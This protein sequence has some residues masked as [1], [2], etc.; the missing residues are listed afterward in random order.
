MNEFPVKDLGPACR[1]AAPLHLLTS[2]GHGAATGCLNSWTAE[3]NPLP[4]L[5]TDGNLYDNTRKT[6]FEWSQDNEKLDISDV[7]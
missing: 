4:K 6:A 5:D 1:P 7:C 3:T 2:H